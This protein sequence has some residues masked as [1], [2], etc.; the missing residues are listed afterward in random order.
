M[1]CMITPLFM[2][3]WSSLIISASESCWTPNALACL[4]I[5]LDARECRAA[6]VHDQVCTLLLCFCHPQTPAYCLTVPM[7]SS[8]SMSCRA[9]LGE[10][11]N[12]LRRTKAADLFK[13]KV[14]AC[15]KVS[16]QQ[17]AL[18]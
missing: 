15:T 12:G 1:Q 5:Q 16:A 14:R 13:L 10:K 3:K 11:L 6:E 17:F 9:S 4:P 18:A 7:C 8:Q 2:L